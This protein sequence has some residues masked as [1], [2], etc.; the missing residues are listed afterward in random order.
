MANCVAKFWLCRAVPGID[1]VEGVELGD[2]CAFDYAQQVESCIGD[3]A[4]AIGE[5]DQREHRARRPNLSVFGA[6]CFEGGKRKDHIADRAGANEQTAHYF[7]PYSLRALSRSTIRASSTARSRV[8][9]LSRSMPVSASPSAS[10]L[11]T[12]AM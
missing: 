10:R 2:A 8:I 7:R 3:G 11:D 1:R 6:R 4:G 9:W 5:A 12:F